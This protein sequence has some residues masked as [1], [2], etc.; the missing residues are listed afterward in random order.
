M[1]DFF[2]GVE[3][4]LI[5]VFWDMWVGLCGWPLMRYSRPQPTSDGAE[6]AF[7]FAIATLRLDGRGRRMPIW[8]LAHVFDLTAARPD[9]ARSKQS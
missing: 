9:Q 8:R 6:R 4:N 7:R 5:V 3:G 2:R 1:H